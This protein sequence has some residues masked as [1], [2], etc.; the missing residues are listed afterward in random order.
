MSKT[1]QPQSSLWRAT[2]PLTATPTTSGRATSLR[3]LADALLVA[4]GSSTEVEFISDQAPG[5]PVHWYGDTA[6]AQALGVTLDTP[7]ATGLEATVRWLSES[8]A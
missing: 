3:E 5:N 6:K 8:R 2:H 7:L 4:T 1:L